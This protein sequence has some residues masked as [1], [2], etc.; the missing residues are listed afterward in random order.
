MLQETLH[1]T[2]LLK[3]L[4]KMYRY[5]MDP[6]RTG[7]A[8]EQTW[9]AGRMDGWMERQTDGQTDGVKPIYS[10]NNILVV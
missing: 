10:P 7:G 9:D 2:H 1:T 8:T 4:D 3:L 5:E 6:A